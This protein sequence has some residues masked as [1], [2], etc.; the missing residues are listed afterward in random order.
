MQNII[1]FFGFLL[2]STVAMAH[3]FEFVT[4]GILSGFLSLIIL[5][6][7]LFKLLMKILEKKQWKLNPFFQILITITLSLVCSVGIGTMASFFYIALF[8]T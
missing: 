8:E 6:Y 1:L 2:I 3:G 4:Y 7:F 5:P